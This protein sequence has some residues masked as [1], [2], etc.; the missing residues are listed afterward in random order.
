MS[1]YILAIDEGTTGAK[2]LLMNDSLKVI[3]EKTI[4]FDQHF[5]Q[6]GWVEH[7]ADQIW[8]AVEEAIQ[9]VVSDIDTK[10]IAAIG[11][12]NQR[13]TIC[14]WDKKTLKSLCKAIVWQDR[15]TAE[16]CQQLKSQNFESVVQ[17]KTG[18]LLDPY[19]SST[20]IEWALK[21]NSAVATAAA[22]G[23]LAIGTIDSFLLARLTE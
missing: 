20:K 18:L 23:S 4:P 14:F 3:A 17:E 19:F 22:N 9:F 11:I 7:D 15:R 2:A 10:K 21:N 5:P 16:R 12:T 8:K 6:P 1:Q 13:E